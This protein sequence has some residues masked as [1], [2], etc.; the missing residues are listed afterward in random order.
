VTRRA[1]GSPDHGQTSFTTV[2]E[3][4]SS[5][6]K[7]LAPLVSRPLSSVTTSCEIRI[8]SQS[9]ASISAVYRP[10][11]SV[12]STTAPFRVRSLKIVTS[13]PS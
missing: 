7:L 11:R 6:T 4:R 13:A 10:F 12:S 3:L 8:R 5:I 1:R 9:S 2:P